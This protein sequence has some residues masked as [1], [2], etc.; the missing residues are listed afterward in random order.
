ML[1][2]FC[3]S[4]AFPHLLSLFT[5]FPDPNEPAEYLW[6]WAAGQTPPLV[7]DGP[8]SSVRARQVWRALQKL[9]RLNR[10]WKQHPRTWGLSQNRLILLDKTKMPAYSIGLG[11]VSSCNTQNP[12][13][14]LQI[15]QHMKPWKWLSWKKAVSSCHHRPE[16]SYYWKVQ[17]NNHTLEISIKIEIISREIDNRKTRWQY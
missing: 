4:P 8:Q 16:G 5:L 13:E 6:E 7:S 12:Y 9:R 15:I 1:Y 11:C 17:M 14:A 10:H 2:I 3:N